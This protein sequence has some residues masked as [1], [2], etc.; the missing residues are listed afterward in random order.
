M[1]VVPWEIA[2][3]AMSAALGEPLDASLA[4]LDDA[5]AARASSFA[6]VLAAETTAHGRATTIA[7]ALA[8]IARDVQ[9]MGLS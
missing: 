7:S 8:V 5:A 1:V 3:V 2:F 4:A 6:R 9:A